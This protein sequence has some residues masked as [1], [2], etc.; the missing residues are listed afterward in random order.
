[1]NAR[2]PIYNSGLGKWGA[3]SLKTPFPRHHATYLY[4]SRGCALVGE[5]NEFPLLEICTYTS[6]HG[7]RERNHA[8]PPSAMLVWTRQLK[9]RASQFCTTHGRNCSSVVS[10]P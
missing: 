5:S 2:H 10:E 9:I 3:S 1:M 7:D 4:R 6:H 8:D